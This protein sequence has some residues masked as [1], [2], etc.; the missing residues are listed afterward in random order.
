MAQQCR[1]GLPRS[2]PAFRDEYGVTGRHAVPAWPTKEHYAQTTEQDFQAAIGED[3]QGAAKSAA[4]RVRKTS[5][6]DSQNVKKPGKNDILQP[7]ASPYKGVKIG[8]AGLEPAT[9]AL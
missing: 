2:L 5:Q 8:R 7:L 9:K 6:A 1:I 3:P 4:V